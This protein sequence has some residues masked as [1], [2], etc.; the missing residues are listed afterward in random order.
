MTGGAVAFRLRRLGLFQLGEEGLLVGRHEV[1]HEACGLVVARFE[2][3]G[4]VD[5][6]GPGDVDDDAR[7]AGREQPVA[8]GGDKTP[9]LLADPV[10]H[11]E[12]HIG[13]IDDHA[14]RVAE[15]EDMHV[16]L[17]G[18]I[19]DEARALAVAGNARVISDGGLGFGRGRHDRK[20]AERAARANSDGQGRPRPH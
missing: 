18:Q 14:I 9:L 6:K 17:F 1:D 2:D 19:G 12:A 11:L 15:R 20:A 7:F 5:E 16:D 3:E 10:R 4:L 13:R 8:I